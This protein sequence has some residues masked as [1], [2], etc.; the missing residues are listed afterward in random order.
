NGFGMRWPTPGLQITYYWEGVTYR[1]ASGSRPTPEDYDGRLLVATA[2]DFDW[3]SQPVARTI[4]RNR[5]GPATF[6]LQYPE[7]NV[8]RYDY[9]GPE[10]MLSTVLDTQT[11]RSRTT[12]YDQW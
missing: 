1:G 3:R 6:T 10:G 9:N 5:L 8:Y 7:G 2:N 4:S 11:G 12:S